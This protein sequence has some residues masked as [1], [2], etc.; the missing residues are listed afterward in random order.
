[1]LA[2]GGR[3]RLTRWSRKTLEG[4]FQLAQKAWELCKLRGLQSDR[5]IAA[6]ELSALSVSK[7]DIDA[8][9]DL[10]NNAL[11]A[12]TERSNLVLEAQI[13]ISLA[14]L[15]EISG[16]RKAALETNTRALQKAQQGKNLYVQS[17]AFG[18]IGRMWLAADPELARVSIPTDSLD[19][20]H[21]VTA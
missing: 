15:R 16:D 6:L 18:E 11:E 13:L 21:E 9:R 14:G 1:M 4:A 7:G 2:F 19:L 3:A 8:S 17:R 12:A 20:L 5:P 10:L